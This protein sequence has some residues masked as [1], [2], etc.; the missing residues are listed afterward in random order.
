LPKREHGKKKMKSLWQ[1]RSAIFGVQIPGKPTTNQLMQ[2]APE[3][4]L[5]ARAVDTLGEKIGQVV[6]TGLM[7]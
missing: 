2:D 7:M 3:K 1:R 6:F 5:V 4:K